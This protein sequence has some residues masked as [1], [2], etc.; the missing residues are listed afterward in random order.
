MHKLPFNRFWLLIIGA[1]LAI[2]ILNIGY[3]KYNE[4]LPKANTN[5]NLTA[6]P[7]GADAVLTTPEP[8]KSATFSA[9][10]IQATKQE[11]ANPTIDTNPIQNNQ[12]IQPTSAAEILPSPTVSQQV[13]LSIKSVGDY[14]INWQENDTAWTIMQRASA[15]YHFAM[16]YKIYDFGIYIM[17]IGGKVVPQNYYWALY[18]NENYSMVGVRDLKVNPNDTVAWQLETW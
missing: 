1:V 12:P 11:T 13:A 6:N 8:Q 18:Y 7:I 10:N 2:S 4:N 15:K 5:Q 14:K 3:A 16:T 17:T 9:Q